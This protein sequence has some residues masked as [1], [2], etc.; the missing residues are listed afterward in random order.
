M[1]GRNERLAYIDWMRGL[2]CVLMFQTHCYDSW[3][4][5]AARADEF[6][7]WSRLG[8]TL[9]APLFLF[10]AGVSCALV[11][12][13]LRRKGVAAERDR[14]Q[15]DPARRGNFRAWAAVSRAGI[16]A[17]AALGAVDR[18]AAR[19]RS[20][21]DRNFADADGRGVLAARSSAR[22][23][24]WRSRCRAAGSRWP[25]RRCGPPGG[26]AGCRGTSSRISTACTRSTCR[27]RGSFRFSRGRRSRLR[28][29]RWD[30]SCSAIGRRKIRA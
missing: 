21:H 19:G 26:R 5:A 22:T 27:S 11:T 1:P 25:R 29:W 30:F 24:F 7:G 9:P 20:E 18:P 28:G 3:L 17:R 4:G 16:R 15:H 8:G 14:A 23:R 13:Q 12:D 10:L 6:L 2:A